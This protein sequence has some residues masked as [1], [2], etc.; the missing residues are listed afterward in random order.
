MWKKLETMA[1]L[2]GLGFLAKTEI[3]KKDSIKQVNNK[4]GTTF[5]TPRYSNPLGQNF[6]NQ[7]EAIYYQKAHDWCNDM[8]QI[9]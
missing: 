6:I 7:T 2:P 1:R 3:R 5:G 8:S 4:S 9:W